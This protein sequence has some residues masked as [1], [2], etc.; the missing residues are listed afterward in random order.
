MPQPRFR[1]VLKQYWPRGT[2]SVSAGKNCRAPPSKANQG[3]ICW[4]L[5]LQDR[6]S[7]LDELFADSR[8]G[9]IQAQLML[10][11]AL[12]KVVG[13][14]GPLERPKIFNN[15]KIRRYGGIINR[16]NYW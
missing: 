5:K 9:T 11:L 6:G 10:G 16:A 12:T 13:R 14:T 8:P 4:Q 15:R 1:V 2:E 3:A 7:K